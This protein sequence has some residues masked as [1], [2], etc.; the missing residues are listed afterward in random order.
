[1]ISVEAR[2]NLY[3]E[4]CV[5]GDK[6]LTVRA[7]LLGAI[8]KGKTKIVNPLIAKDTLATIECV[9]K[10]GAT[11]FISG[12]EILITGAK[13]VN[14]NV[15]FDCENS[16]T[17]ARLLIGLLSGLK[18]NATIIG[19]SS[20][21]ARPMK[22]VCDPLKLRGACVN[23][24]NGCLPVYIK[25]A[26]LK[27]CVY[28]MEVDSAQVKSAI[29]L[30][31]VTAGVNT[32]IIEKN[33]TRDHTEKILPLFGIKV[34]QN[35]NKIQVDAGNL[36]GAK[37]VIPRDP[38]SSAYY[39]AMGLLLGEV[40][41][42]GV[43]LSTARDGFFEK[44][45]CA[46]AKIEYANQK[47]SPFGKVADITAYKSAIE[48]FEVSTNELPTMID[49]IPLICAIATLNKGCKIIGAKE[50][51]FKESDRLNSTRELLQL[52]GGKCEICDNDLLVYPLQKGS[53]FEYS[54]EDHRM[55]M[56]AF[57]LMSA[58]KGGSLKQ[59]SAEISFPDFY[60]NYYKLPLGLIGKNLSKSLS[61]K[62]HKFILSALG[63]ENFSYEQ[64]SLPENKLN[65]FFKK[66]S[67]KAF[68]GTIPYK[69]DLFLYAKEL[70]ADAKKA[71]S[72]NY[73]LNGKGYTTDGKGLVTACFYFGE[74]IKGR[75]VLVYGMGGA[76]RSI[77]LAF[78]KAGATVF[79]D[80][81]TKQK[82]IDFC[83]INKG[84]VLY[85]NQNCDI[86]INATSVVD[87]L[88]FTE[89]QIL[90]AKFVIDI[91][92]GNDSAILYFAKQNGIKC[93]D[94]KAMLFFQAYYSDLLLAG[95]KENKKQAINLY[96]A[97]GKKYEDRSY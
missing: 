13:K 54:S 76:G 35:K 12:N 91:N 63:V 1:M 23:D 88:V 18:V 66:C 43:L 16:A 64:L 69:K 32:V 78:L 81:R 65:G 11:V 96:N 95:K 83:A 61:G 77:A 79:V 36:N 28:E 70:S 75:K 15:T 87:N 85:D 22:R 41:V 47:K 5:N 72:V 14:D 46:G 57:V 29:I 52:A 27:D 74:E 51:R 60:K 55:E 10:L 20:L 30:S 42:K 82:A 33:A 8:A 38:S 37:I 58:I 67:Y 49:E 93:Y 19:D 9:K 3:A 6:S 80:N 17:L 53:F 97:Y 89:S 68:N 71:Q 90:N 21:S 48:Y 45:K 7:L 86:L 56:T 84:A 94:G 73:L 26:T 25:P 4:F 24:T 31:G 62:I 50:L 39:F 59:K 40:T 34:R 92:Y 2:Q 44:L